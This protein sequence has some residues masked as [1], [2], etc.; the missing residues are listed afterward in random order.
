[1]TLEEV[2]NIRFLWNTTIQEDLENKVGN[3]LCFETSPTK[4]PTI[5][6]ETTPA[7]SPNNSNPLPTCNP[8]PSYL[9]NPQ[10]RIFTPD[11]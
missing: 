2:S 4:R 7:P 5:Y 10:T 8:P 3:L 11:S 6:I 9:E 1:M